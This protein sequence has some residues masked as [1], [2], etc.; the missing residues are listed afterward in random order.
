M[1]AVRVFVTVEREYKPG[2]WFTTNGMVQSSDEK[3]AAD[4]A[5]L[6]TNSIAEVSA[7]EPKTVERVKA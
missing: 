4:A 2:C 5:H 6:L 7:P 1:S 3:I